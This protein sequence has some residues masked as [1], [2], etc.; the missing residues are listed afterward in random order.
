MRKTSQM[1]CWR[2]YE[3]YERETETNPPRRDMMDRI[4]KPEDKCDRQKDN[5]ICF[6]PRDARIGTKT[7]GFVRGAILITVS[8]KLF[9]DSV[10]ETVRLGAYTR[11]SGREAYV[12]VLLSITLIFWFADSIHHIAPGWIGLGFTL[13]Y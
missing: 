9:S 8:Y 7:D 4:G 10:H 13:V 5:H 2:S 6:A 12:I 11:I 1:L 3:I